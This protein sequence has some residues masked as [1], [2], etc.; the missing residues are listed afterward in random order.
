MPDN[1]QGQSI[2]ITSGPTRAN[3]DAVRYITNRSSGRLG[4]AIATEA[5]TRG[6]EVTLVRG[7]GS[8]KPQ[9]GS[10][11][12]KAW[13][14]LRIKRIETVSDLL[15]TLGT[16]L[17][18]SLPCSAVIHAMAVL[19]YVPKKEQ[20]QKV[21]S[22]KKDWKI[23]LRKTPKV[24]RK[25]KKWNPTT[26]LV[27]FKLEVDKDDDQLKQIAQSLIQDT[28]ADLV[29]ANDLS[30]I[31]DERHP[32]LLINDKGEIIGN[33]QTKPDIATALC[34]VLARSLAT[35]PSDT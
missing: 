34:D 29:V 1:L 27:G 19:D 21:R 28:R 26:F 23:E 18:S 11:P 9:R 12:D 15:E 14:R 30:K 10:M 24:I 8:R 4:C 2:L 17:T 3:I 5:A 6:A 7:A 35:S 22:G 25:I 13:K 32:A 20:S 33:P 16:E 31:R